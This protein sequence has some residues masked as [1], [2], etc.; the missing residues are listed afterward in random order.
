[1]GSED[2]QLRREKNRTGGHD[3]GGSGGRDVD[4]RSDSQ[5]ID[6]RG[7]RSSDNASLSS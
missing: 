4:R 5:T 6:G 3:G 1:M 2:D 7:E